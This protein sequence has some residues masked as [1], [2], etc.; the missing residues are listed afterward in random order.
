MAQGSLSQGHSAVV[1]AADVVVV[2][3]DIGA[4]MNFIKKAENKTKKQREKK[5]KTN[6][7]QLPQTLSTIKKAQCQQSRRSTVE[8][9]PGKRRESNVNDANS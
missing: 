7:K 3:I 6:E 9:Q 8:Q 4:Q 1:V 2:A 5:P